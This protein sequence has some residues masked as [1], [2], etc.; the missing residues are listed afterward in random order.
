MILFPSAIQMKLSTSGCCSL[1]PVLHVCMCVCMYPRGLVWSRQ[2]NSPSK[3]H[4]QVGTTLL[5][6][7]LFFFVNICRLHVVCLG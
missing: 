4:G 1:V 2:L 7:Y 3:P 6:L 5:S